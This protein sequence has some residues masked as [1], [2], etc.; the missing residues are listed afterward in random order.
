MA[1]YCLE[2]WNRINGTNDPPKKYIISKEL[3]LCEGCGEWKNVII[4]ERK[5]R[6]K[7]KLRFFIAAF[8]IIYTILYVLM[9]LLILPYLIY[10]RRKTNLRQK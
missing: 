5:Y 8:K 7:Y 3:D 6:Y 1:E 4:I 10:K 2:C 9:R